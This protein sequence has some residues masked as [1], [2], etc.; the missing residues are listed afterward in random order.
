MKRGLQLA[1]LL[2]V[3]MVFVMATAGPA[4]AAPYYGAQMV[5]INRQLNQ[6]WMGQFQYNR[7]HLRW[8]SLSYM[9]W[10]TDLC[11][12][13]LNFGNS[14]WD[15]HRACIRHDFGYRNLKRI[16]RTFGRDVWS[17]GNKANVD[18][19][20]GR[21]MADRCGEW[22]WWVRGA[23]KD[24][25]RAYENTVRLFGGGWPTTGA[26]RYRLTWPW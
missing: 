25:A 14:H 1:I 2:P 9:D 6:T 13:P 8:S 20:F 23:C 4:S 11:S 16:E 26:Y 10:S 24:T 21:D 15:F 3:I 17:Y 19:Q 12:A 5:E 22:N 18:T 7:N